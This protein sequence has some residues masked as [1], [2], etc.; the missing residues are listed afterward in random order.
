MDSM[1]TRVR[2]RYATTG[3]VIPLSSHIA[4]KVYSHCPVEW[5][6]DAVSTALDWPT[7]HISFM[8]TDNC[9]KRHVLKHFI[10]KVLCSNTLLTD[11]QCDTEKVVWVDVVKEASPKDYSGLCRCACDFGSCC[12]LCMVPSC[13]ECDGCGNNGCCRTGDCGHNCCEQ[14]E[15]V[16]ANRLCPYS[17]CSPSCLGS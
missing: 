6:F 1:G 9:H 5:Y 10:R 17:G 8:V 16:D 12:Q 15:I 3:E 13:R 4:T 11:L 2:F 14:A 7:S